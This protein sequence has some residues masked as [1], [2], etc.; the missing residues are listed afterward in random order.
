[1]DKKTDN[2]SDKDDI[3][4]PSGRRNYSIGRNRMK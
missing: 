2:S 4:K 3:K 1:M